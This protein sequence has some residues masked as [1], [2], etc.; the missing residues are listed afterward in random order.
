M[1][2]DKLWIWSMC[3][4]KYAMP[5]LYIQGSHWVHFKKIEDFL[6]PGDSTYFI[7]LG[8]RVDS[9][10][11][12]NIRFFRLRVGCW[13]M[14]YLGIWSSCIMVYGTDWK[15]QSFMPNVTTGMQQLQWFGLLMASYLVD[16]LIGSKNFKV[17][18]IEIFQIIWQLVF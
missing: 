1:I 16:F 13:R 17:S 9:I 10:F 14:E 6:S 4:I 7:F 11:C 15:H 3:Q 5:P 12:P 8:S 2:L 18:D